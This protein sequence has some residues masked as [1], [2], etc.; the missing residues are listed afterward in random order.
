MERKSALV[1]AS[2]SLDSNLVFGIMPEQIGSELVNLTN[3]SNRKHIRYQLIQHGYIVPDGETWK[4]RMPLF[5][6]WLRKF[7]ETFPG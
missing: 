5:D 4:M 7:A 2:V 6:F 3:R 1:P